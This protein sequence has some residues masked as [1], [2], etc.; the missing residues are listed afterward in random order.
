M[1]KAFKG[2]L[3][4]VSLPPLLMW[5]MCVRLCFQA[6]LGSLV[7]VLQALARR[8]NAKE[9]DLALHAAHVKT[10]RR[11]LTSACRRQLSE[12]AVHLAESVVA[13]EEVS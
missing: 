8:L 10:L 13:D 1:P 6:V 11:E 4:C 7:E 5:R 2:H 12:A 3:F 9:Q